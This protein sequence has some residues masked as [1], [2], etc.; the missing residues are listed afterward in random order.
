MQW[1]DSTPAT[2]SGTFTSATPTTWNARWRAT[3]HK[4]DPKTY[5]IAPPAILER[6][7]RVGS[8]W[9]TV[10]TVVAMGSVT[11]LAILDKIPGQWAAV[12]IL[13]LAGV[14]QLPQ[15]IFARPKG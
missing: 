2:A 9:S 4:V 7:R 10:S 11:T 15:W 5:S 14:L 1:S 6:E 8:A 13:A 12:G 3:L